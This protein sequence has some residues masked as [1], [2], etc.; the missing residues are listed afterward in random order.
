MERVAKNLEL[1]TSV[2][3]D[4]V[5]KCTCGDTVIHLFR[6]ADSSSLKKTRERLMIFLKGTKKKK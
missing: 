3:L 2:Y 6:S 5:N 1:A 4:R